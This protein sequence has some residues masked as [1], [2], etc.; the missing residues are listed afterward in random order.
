MEEEDGCCDGKERGICEGDGGVR[1]GRWRCQ[2][3]ELRESEW[4]LV[5]YERGEEA[6][7]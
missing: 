7:R 3:R 1:R 6:G 2:E 5:L 4:G